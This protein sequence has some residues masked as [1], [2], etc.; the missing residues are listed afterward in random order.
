MLKTS[1]D[2]KMR[3]NEDISNSKLLS[4]RIWKNKSVIKFLQKLIG[5]LDLFGLLFFRLFAPSKE[6]G[7]EWTKF[8][9]ELFNEQSHLKPF[10]MVLRNEIVAFILEL[11][12]NVPNDGLAFSQRDTV[13]N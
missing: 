2:F 7:E 5:L 13:V 1:P 6:F 3:V 12:S 9:R 11:L 4:K 8:F 10:N